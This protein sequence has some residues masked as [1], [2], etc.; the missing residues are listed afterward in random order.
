MASHITH[1]DP[2]S[3]LGRGRLDGIAD[4]GRRMGAGAIISYRLEKV[5]LGRKPR[6]TEQVLG[7]DRRVAGRA[8][9]RHGFL[10]EVPHWRVNRGVLVV[11]AEDRKRV[12]TELRRWTT[13]V[14]WW[15]IELNRR[16]LRQLRLGTR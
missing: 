13:A 6:F 7:M 14:E 9:H 15:P 12:V 4:G 3:L 10:D 5:P 8:Y 16:H 11:K 1:N 2:A